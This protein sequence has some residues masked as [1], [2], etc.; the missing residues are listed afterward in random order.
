M[1]EV[2]IDAWSNIFLYSLLKAY[3]SVELTDLNFWDSGLKEMR[4]GYLC[5]GNP[6]LAICC[7]S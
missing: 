4:F 7:G 1:K 6:I 2:K 3:D 5:G